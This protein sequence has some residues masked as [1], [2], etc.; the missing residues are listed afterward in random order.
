MSGRDAKAKNPVKATKTTFDIV[1]SL[2]ALNGGGV[3]EIADFVGLPKS[4]VHNYLST[5]HEEGYV[6]KSG[7]KYHVGIRFLELGAFARHNRPIFDVA[8]PEVE[9]LA[10]ETG[11]VSNL[12]IEELG[13]G[14]Y[15]YR[16]RGDQAVNV[17]VQTGTRVNLHNNALGKAILAHMP[18]DRVS[19]ILNRHGLPKSTENTI[20]NKETLVN[21][22]GDIRKRGVAFD[23]EERIIGLRCAAAPILSQNNV[24]QG[25]ISVSGPTSRLQ[26]EWFEEGVPKLLKEAANVIELNSTYS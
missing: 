5:L 15:I 9:A 12:M 14:Y 24:V 8:K 13:F 11:E 16:R 25:A 1:Q 22:F 19:R 2:L 21:E 17:N 6:V 26:G 20:T 3:T 7:T 10:K 4:S 23:N 18:R